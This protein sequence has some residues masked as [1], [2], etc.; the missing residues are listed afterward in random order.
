MANKTATANKECQTKH[1]NDNVE[2]FQGTWK[3]NDWIVDASEPCAES[4]DDICAPV[5]SVL[6]YSLIT[7]ATDRYP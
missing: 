1:G 4:A 7:I 5:N 6:I 2:P 3:I